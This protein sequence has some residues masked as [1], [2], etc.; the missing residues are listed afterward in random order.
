[1][2]Q[3]LVQAHYL[4]P[5]MKGSVAKT[6][7]DPTKPMGIHGVTTGDIYADWDIDHLA[8]TMAD[9]LAGDDEPV[10]KHSRQPSENPC[11]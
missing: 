7:S 9:V 10:T 3:T 5:R 1:M 2:Y 4:M 6:T 11:K 8:A